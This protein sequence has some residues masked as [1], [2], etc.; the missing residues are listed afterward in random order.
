MSMT[1]II[2]VAARTPAGLNAESSAAAARAGL[3]RRCDFPFSTP[4]GDPVVVAADA[5][6]NAKIEGR[7]RLIP[8]IESALA[9][10]FDKLAQGEA[11]QGKCHLLLALP[12]A[13]PG[14]SDDDAQW[15]VD[16]IGAVLAEKATRTEVS[17][18]G[19]GHAGTLAAI[20]QAARQ[21]AQGS[22]ELHI[23]LGAD[24]YHHA[25]TFVHLERTLQ[26]DQPT[27]R[28]GFVPGEGAACLALASSQ[29][30]Q[31]LQLPALALV[32][33]VR[34]AWE[35]LL[36]DSETGTFGVGM[37]EAVLG[38]AAGLKLPDEAV[39]TLYSDINGERYRSEEWGFVAMRTPSLWRS[40]DYEA[41]A[42]C[43]GDSGAAF[44][45][46][47]AMLAVQ[48]YAKGYAKGPRTMVMAGSESGLRGAM[49]LTNPRGI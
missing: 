20:D 30:A 37:S 23:I 39:D 14:F 4:E 38:A 26:F 33:G 8:M 40:L 29:L 11:Y 9:E 49:L 27:I 48:S 12:E 5:K 16:S 41:P 17:L 35:D 32:T 25:Q 28:G 7:D 15:V 10:L 31:Q 2:A 19:R 3:S 18:V 1:E 22:D 21:I 36:R 24:T 13:R 6:L 47:A 42:D 45:T 43:W 44:G 34:M 46:L